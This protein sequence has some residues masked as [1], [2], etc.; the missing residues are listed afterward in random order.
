M[1]E[2]VLRDDINKYEPKPFFGFTRRKAFFVALTLAVA[3][4]TF[5]LFDEFKIDP[6]ITGYVLIIEG[7]LI[8]IFG[9]KKFSGL[10]LE[11]FIAVR[12]GEFCVPKRLS[13]KTYT[14]QSASD[15]KLKEVK[16]EFT[17]EQ[18]ALNKAEAE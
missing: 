6:I 16:G 7:I 1:I 10:S 8:S 14:I 18:K 2:I 11:K 13:I 17:K 5:N 15:K 12:F 3:F 4:G 9:F